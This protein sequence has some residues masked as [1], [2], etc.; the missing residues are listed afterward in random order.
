MYTEEEIRKDMDELRDHVDSLRLKYGDDFSGIIVSG[1]KL[2][3]YWAGSSL[4]CGESFGLHQNCHA[5]LSRVRFIDEFFDACKC[6][7]HDQDKPKV[8]QELENMNLESIKRLLILKTEEFKKARDERDT[9]ESIR[10]LLHDAG[11]S[12]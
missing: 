8:L 12:N 7:L 5:L 10:Q 2:D 4:I 11:F 3:K 6:V 1:V 9:E